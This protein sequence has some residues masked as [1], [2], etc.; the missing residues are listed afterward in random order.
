MSRLVYIPSNPKK[1]MFEVDRVV[2]RGGRVI[3]MLGRTPI[4]D[5]PLGIHERYD[6]EF[7][8]VAVAIDE[9]SIDYKRAL[10]DLI[11]SLT[12]DDHMGDVC[13]SIE[14][15][16]REIHDPAYGEWNDLYELR[17]ILRGREVSPAP[18]SIFQRDAA[19]E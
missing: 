1:K 19:L 14:M 16:L 9:P 15:C 11:R 10:Y 2:V 13:D 12:L 5:H 3:H 6:T 7:P 18:L 8:K 4:D 17:D